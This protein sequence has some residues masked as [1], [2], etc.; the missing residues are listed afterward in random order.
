MLVRVSD[1]VTCPCCGYVT[2]PSRGDYELCPVCFWEDD[3]HQAQ[4]PNSPDG[5]N[6]ISLVD[7]QQ[8]YLRSGAMHP[9]FLSRVR[10]A[11]RDEPRDPS[12][13]PYDSVSGV[14]QP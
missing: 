2:L 7:A 9:E 14:E 11:K 5:P 4:R 1:R 8:T 3:P 12:W 13:R 10:H 6:N